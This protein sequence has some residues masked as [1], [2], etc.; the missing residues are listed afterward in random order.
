MSDAALGLAVALLVCTICLAYVMVGIGLQGGDFL[1]FYTA[2]AVAVH[3]Q[4]DRL[5]DQTY[6]HAAQHSV[7]AASNLSSLYPPM[8]AL[9]MAPLAL[10]P[11][12]KALALWWLVQAACFLATGWMLY[13]NMQISRAWRVVAL[14]A[15]AALLP[16]WAAVW[17]GHLS[18]LLLLILTS[19]LTLH[20][21]GA[22]T[23]AGVVLSAL[24][25]KPQF[26]LGIFLWLVVRRD[27]RAMAGMAAGGLAQALAVS[28]FLGPSI[29]FDYLH[30]LPTITATVRTYR[31]SAVSEQSFAG[32]VSNWMWAHG[33]H[34]F[35]V[36]ATPMRLAHIL[37]AGLAA[38]LLCRVVWA[39]RERTA[40]SRSSER[41][42]TGLGSLGGGR[43]AAADPVL[44]YE[45]VAAVLFM[46]LFPPYL[47][48]YDLTLL[49]VP[50][51]LL[52]SS[53]C[54]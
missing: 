30:A 8:L 1:Q 7:R 18:P 29:C 24:A 19:G 39:C 47:Q 22:G 48:V 9:L 43:P 14:V 38:V 27:W 2:G 25:L 34:D 52:W 4:A 35:N 11:H 12:S 10:L 6:F 36:H 31:Y 21:R 50:L 40:A 32:I 16:V 26:A 20:R 51:A 54:W 53:P 23:W 41:P 15:L 28:I 45:Y 44:P 13:T 3:G 37:T 46:M 5:Y 42:A 17:L 33:C 49:A